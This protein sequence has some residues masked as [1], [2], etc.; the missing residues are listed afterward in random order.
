MDAD[1]DDEIKALNRAIAVTPGDAG[2]LRLRATRHHV[3]S[4]QALALRDYDE[5]MRLEP[6]RA[7]DHLDRGQLYRSMGVLA[8]ALEDLDMAIALQPGSAGLHAVRAEIRAEA[9]DAHGAFSDYNLVIAQQPALGS[10]RRKRAELLAGPLAR[11][12]EALQEYAELIRS[13]D[14]FSDCEDRGNL[15][16][17]LGCWEEAVADYDAALERDPYFDALDS[18]YTKRGAV[19]ARLGDWRRVADNCD[20]W[21][22]AD[23]HSA[24]AMARRG[25]ARNRLGDYAGAVE[26]FALAEARMDV[27]RGGLIPDTPEPDAHLRNYLAWFFATAPDAQSRDGA[28]AVRLAREACEITEW[29]KADYLDTYAAA[30]AQAGDFNEA[31]RQQERALASPEFETRMGIAARARLASYRDGQPFIEDRESG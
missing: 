7:S 29:R 10:F 20:R 6:G 18:I 14:D 24:W 8:K 21:L 13:G 25:I 23:P 15:N 19:L 12:Q 9:G 27:P 3:L 16:A 2:L 26:D 5:A 1:A 30:C 28:R 17:R 31:V 22:K 4:R 11:P